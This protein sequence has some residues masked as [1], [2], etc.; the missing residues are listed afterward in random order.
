[1]GRSVV[2][3]ALQDVR[4][5]EKTGNRAHRRARTR[6]SARGTRPALREGSDLLELEHP[7]PADRRDFLKTAAG[8]L[9]LLLS[10]QGL[11]LRRRR[12]RMSR[13]PRVPRSASA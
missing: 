7:I 13:F 6:K 2:L 9:S 10:R 4:R 12:L 3:N 8:T 11:V 5:A 1:M